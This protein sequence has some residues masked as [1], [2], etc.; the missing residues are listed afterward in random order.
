MKT[1]NIDKIVLLAIIFSLIGDFLGLIAE[2]LAQRRDR[3]E[4][5]KTENEKTSLLAQI[6][7]LEQR[8]AKLEKLD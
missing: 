1:D 7:K 8:L 5:S 4:E 2:V 3:Q 6:T